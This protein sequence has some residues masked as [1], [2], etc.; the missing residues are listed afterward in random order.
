M[1]NILTTLILVSLFRFGYSQ[2]LFSVGNK[3]HN[4]VYI[5]ESFTVENE[6][7]SLLNDTIIDD[8]IYKKLSLILNS[9]IDNPKTIGFLRETE[10][11]KIY[12]RPDTANNDYLIYDFKANM[13]D[14][15]EVYGITGSK[16]QT[17]LSRF[18]L[19]VNQIDSVTIDN[20][21]YKQIHLMPVYH[22]EDYV[23]DVWIE[24]IGN[25]NGFLHCY[26]GLVGGNT[27][28]LICYSCE[29][30]VK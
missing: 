30:R 4:L 1:K 17:E 23:T 20:E 13:G 3:W 8:L 28:K 27:Y 2:E 21:N 16:N 9:K 11:Q 29:S 22:D 14:T 5:N 19:I 10:D 7:L 12:F 24:K 18:E 26:A 6:S 25:K 15:L